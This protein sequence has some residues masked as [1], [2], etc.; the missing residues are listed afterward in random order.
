MGSGR[1]YPVAVVLVIGALLCAVSFGGGGL[2]ATESTGN[3]TANPEPFPV[4]AV[5]ESKRHS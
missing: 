3:S 4:G 5:V 2:S 1:L